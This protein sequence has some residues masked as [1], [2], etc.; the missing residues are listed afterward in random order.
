METMMIPKTV[1]LTR[2]AFMTTL[3]SFHKSVDAYR[4]VTTPFYTFNYHG[5]SSPRVSKKTSK[6]F[7]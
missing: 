3:E 7:L 1:L 4:L 2:A 5:A 6:C